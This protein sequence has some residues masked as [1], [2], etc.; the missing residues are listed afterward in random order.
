MNKW[1]TRA[2][3]FYFPVLAMWFT[4]PRQPH[5]LHTAIGLV[6]SAI[7]FSVVLVPAYRARQVTKIELAA[8]GLNSSGNELRDIEAVTKAKMDVVMNHK[9]SDNT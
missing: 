4:M 3:Y 7:A 9:A 1:I 5:W 8:L 2:G 6:L